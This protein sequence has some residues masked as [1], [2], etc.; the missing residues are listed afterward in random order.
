[1][2]FIIYN[3]ITQDFTPHGESTIDFHVLHF[4]N[5]HPTDQ[6][7]EICQKAVKSFYSIFDSSWKISQPCVK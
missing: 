5:I 2:S 4:K 6:D 7:L 1:M 3:Y